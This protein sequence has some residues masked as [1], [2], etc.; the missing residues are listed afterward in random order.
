MKPVNTKL[1]ESANPERTSRGQPMQ[2][3]LCYR[4]DL[5]E[6]PLRSLGVV[7][8]LTELNQ[9][10]VESL[11]VNIHPSVLV[12]VAAWTKLY[13]SLDHEVSTVLELRKTGY[14]CWNA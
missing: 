1:T 14:R 12:V 8:Q 13:P 7:F 3:K 5:A 2:A 4:D 10:R 11:A 9:G 6:L